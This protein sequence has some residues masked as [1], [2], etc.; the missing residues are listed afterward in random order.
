VFFSVPIT[1]ILEKGMVLL[2]ALLAFYVFTTLIYV[3]MKTRTRGGGMKEM[4][5]SFMSWAD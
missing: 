5:S 4:F 1:F 2:W 3:Y